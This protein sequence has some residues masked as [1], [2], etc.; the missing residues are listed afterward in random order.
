[1]LTY[2][3]SEI[4]I[5]HTI[6]EILVCSFVAYYHNH[7]RNSTEFE[8]LQCVMDKHMCKLMIQLMV[9]MKVVTFPAVT[10]ELATT[11]NITVT[12]TTS[13]AITPIS[14]FANT[15]KS[16][17]FQLVQALVGVMLIL[18]VSLLLI[19]LV[20]LGQKKNNTSDNVS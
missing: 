17:V 7:S 13:T 16:I 4:I 5:N 9:T 3:N 8:Y 10:V 11:S 12:T 14:T 20:C 2:A 6:P 15:K 18:S 1:M 19:L